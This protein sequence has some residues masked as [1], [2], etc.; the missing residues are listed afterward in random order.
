MNLIHSDP[1]LIKSAPVDQVV[2]EDSNITL[3]CNATGNPTP[4][5]T[6]T[7]DSSSTVLHQG[8]TYSIINIKRQAA[9]EYK[10][11]AWNGVGSQK[12]VTAA[13]N[14]HCEF[15]YLHSCIQRVYPAGIVTCMYIVSTNI[16]II[17]IKALI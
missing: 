12:N 11:T 3:H 10:C 16:N 13:V 8:E 17:M 2:V 15:F 7:K 1:S 4:N 14:V 6:W 9:G 5:I